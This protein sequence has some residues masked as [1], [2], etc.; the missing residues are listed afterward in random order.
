MGDRRNITHTASSLETY[1]AHR[2][3]MALCSMFYE[4]RPLSSHGAVHHTAP[5]TCTRQGCP[6]SSHLFVIPLSAM[7]DQVM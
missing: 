1:G 7:V 6:W 3:P 2:T 4:P 5:A